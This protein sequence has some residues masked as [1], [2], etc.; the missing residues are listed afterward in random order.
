MTINLSHKVRQE[1]RIVFD[2][3]CTPENLAKMAID[4]RREIATVLTT[5]KST[6]MAGGDH[7]DIEIKGRNE[8]I[9]F[10]LEL[11]EKIIPKKLRF[12]F[13]L[14]KIVDQSTTDSEEEEYL[15][16]KIKSLFFEPMEFEYT[17]ISDQGFAQ[18]KTRVKREAKKSV[19]SILLRI[20]FALKY[21]SVVGWIPGLER[22]QFH[23]LE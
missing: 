4:P 16:K 17:F 18:I 14:I 8:T 19:F 21:L 6:P 12:N 1:Q 20:L 11:L 22:K 15:N 5:D 7:V 13:E 23:P 10:R 9:Q 2:Y 3:F